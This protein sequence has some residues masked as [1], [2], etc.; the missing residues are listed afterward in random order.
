M[1]KKLYVTDL[2]KTWLRSDRT[3]S[4]EGKKTWNSLIENDIHITFATARSYEK[5]RSLLSGLDFNTPSIAL[6]GAVTMSADGK[7]ISCYCLSDKQVSSVLEISRSFEIDPFVLGLQ[8]GRDRVLFTHK[9]NELQKQY[10]NHR[11]SD[12][13]L[14]ETA[15]LRQL[16]QP[17]MMNFVGN[18]K[19]LES[20]KEAIEESFGNEL[21]LKFAEDPYQ[22]G[23]FSL[24]ILHP[25]GDKSHAINDLRKRLNIKPEDVVVFGDNHNDIGMFKFAGHGVAV[26]NAVD[27]LKQVADE[28]LYYTNDEDGVAKYLKKV[29][30]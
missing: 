22:K 6:N 23:C 7:L 12:P 30:E 26:N 25:L 16:S 17:I 11:K 5:A 28:I 18:K 4:D 14:L 29:F 1:G 20:L 13:R 21:E 24:E 27:E 10:V 15:N 8:N 3:I 19:E 2:D 9:L